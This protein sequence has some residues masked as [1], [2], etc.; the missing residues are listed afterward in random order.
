MTYEYYCEHCKA[1][2]E[3]EQSISE[4]AIKKSPKC[5]QETAKR[6]IS[7]GTGFILQGGSWAK[8]NYK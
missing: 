2:W 5:Q 6:L 4:D 8:D 3:M 7:A 1:Q